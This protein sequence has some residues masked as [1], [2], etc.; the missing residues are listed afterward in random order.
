MDAERMRAVDAYIG[1][2]AAKTPMS[3]PT[4]RPRSSACTCSIYSQPVHSLI[5]V[6]HTRW[7]VLRYPTPAM[8]QQAGMSTEAFEDFYFDVCTLDYEKMSRA[9]DALVARLERANDVRIV[10]LPG[11]IFPFPSPACPPSSATT[12]GSTSPTARSTPPPVRGERSTGR[13]CS[14]TRPASIR[15]PSLSAPA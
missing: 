2:R 9:M 12:A 10:G 5:R 6:P 14:T 4:C 7:V 15:A 8:A 11:R 13:F 3:S 1:I